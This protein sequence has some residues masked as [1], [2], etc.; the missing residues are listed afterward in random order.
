[1]IYTGFTHHL[2]A[3]TFQGRDSSGAALM[4]QVLSDSPK[5]LSWFAHVLEPKHE[6]QIAY[7]TSL[8]K[9]VCFFH[10]WTY[11]RSYAVT[12]RRRRCLVQQAE[13]LTCWKLSGE[14]IYYILRCRNPEYS[15]PK[16][17]SHLPVP[18]FDIFS[19]AQQVTK[20]IFF[21]C[22]FVG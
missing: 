7:P 8:E 13:F 21:I 2:F 20:R 19:L 3:M 5:N 1:M 15:Q 17:V 10:Y 16:L 12:C 9:H 6:S 22:R 4:D 11:R 18:T 14:I